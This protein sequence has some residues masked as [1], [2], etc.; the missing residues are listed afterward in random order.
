MEDSDFGP[1]SKAILAKREAKL[2]ELIGLDC[3]LG[4]QD[5]SGWTPLH[6]SVYWPVGMEILLTAGVQHNVGSAYITPLKYATANMQDEA[7]LLLLDRDVVKNLKYYILETVL[8]HEYEPS[9]RIV[10]AAIE[11]EVRGS[12][13]LRNLAITHLSRRE[14]DRLCISQEDGPIQILDAY[15][16]LTKEALE[17]VGVKL[18]EDLEPRFVVLSTVYHGLLDL[19][20]VLSCYEKELLVEFADRLWSSGFHDI[21]IC[22]GDEGFT[23]LHQA[24]MQGHLYMASW[25]M[26]HGGDP[27]IVIR[28]HSL[29]AFHLLSENFNR[30]IMVY[31]DFI[32]DN[33]V[34]PYRDALTRM[35]CVCGASCRDHCR[36]AC[37]PEGC[38]PTTI[39]LRAA[40]RTW[41]E[42]K[43]SFLSWCQLIDL[44][45]GAIETCC[46]E[47]ARVE[48]FERLGITHVCCKISFD[49]VSDAMPQD[50]ILEIQDEESEFIDQLE[51]WMALYEEERA[52]FEGSAIQF[53]DEWSDMLKD[54]LDVPEHFEE[55]WRWRCLRDKEIRMP[56]YFAKPSSV[57]HGHEEVDEDQE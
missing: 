48:A 41:C 46:L 42:R 5:R 8:W 25:L 51:S 57:E 28:G 37:S 55:H 31:G 11:A 56:D 6:L 15:A 13:R 47:F 23:P 17:D 35:A 21:N 24:C 36:C 45:P 50:T 43:V 52:K 7:I 9:S 18:P 12:N 2:R 44:S 29:N 39:L 32:I 14:L 1:V 10:T 16:T 30:H 3:D 53:L 40:T 38:T 27:T 19:L 33:T 34:T 26:S 22:N 49:V 54:E 4:E 20:D